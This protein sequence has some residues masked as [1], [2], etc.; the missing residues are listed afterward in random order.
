MVFKLLALYQSGHILLEASDA[1]DEDD[2]IRD[3]LKNRRV[4]FADI[5]NI[6]HDESDSS[7]TGIRND[8]IQESDSTSNYTK[9]KNHDH[10]NDNN[11]NT[12]EREQKR[13]NS[14]RETNFHPMTPTSPL[15]ARINSF[16][17]NYDFHHIDT[18]LRLDA[19]E[20][21]HP[22][23]PLPPYSPGMP[24]LISPGI[25]PGMSYPPPPPPTPPMPPIHTTAT[26][27][28]GNVMKTPTND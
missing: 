11:N 20:S 7:N 9:N 5:P 3:E 2:W 13:D 8:R 12:I 1:D 14:I 23:L 16:E 10:N 22:G 4:T 6:Y 24:G 15:M 21:P 18:P 25:M 27:A 26:N 19:G 28:V 17:E